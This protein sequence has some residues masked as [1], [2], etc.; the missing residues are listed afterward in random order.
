MEGYFYSIF[1]NCVPFFPRQIAFQT[2]MA[3][4]FQNNTFWQVFLVF[5]CNW[6]L[7]FL[8]SIWY[9]LGYYG[10]KCPVAIIPEVFQGVSCSLLGN[11]NFWPLI[12]I[13]IRINIVFFYFIFPLQNTRHHSI[14][15][16]QN[17]T[18]DFKGNHSITC[19]IGNLVFTQALVTHIN[20]SSEQT[21]CQRFFLKPSCTRADRPCLLPHRPQGA[22][23]L[24]IH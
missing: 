20:F 14:T 3:T 17:S 5:Q 11:V 10:R 7:I 24:K 4:V 19:G 16:Q 18:S 8:N 22:S 13:F 9:C 21:P 1:R 23:F 2:K 12:Q 15:M 6:D